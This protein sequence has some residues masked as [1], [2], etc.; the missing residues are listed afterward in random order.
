M[1]KPNHDSEGNVE[2][3]D[4]QNDPLQETGSDSPA[5]HAGPTPRA[6]LTAV[7]LNWNGSDDTRQC[8]ASLEAAGV[9][10]IVVDNGSCSEDVAR[11]ADAVAR[12][13]GATLLRNTE[14]L[15]F[16]SGCNVGIRAALERGARLVLLLNNDATLEP[17]AVDALLAFADSNPRAG[18]VSPLI[19]DSTG[20]RI[21]AAGG[22][23]ARREVVCGLGLTGKPA[24]AAPAEPFQS[25]ALTGC[26]LLIRREVFD[27]VG[28]FDGDYFAYVEDV[29]LSRR[30]ASAGWGLWVVPK[31]RVR[32]RVS[33]SSGGGYTP[34]RSYLLGRGTALFVRKRASLDQRI[35]FTLLAPL[36]LLAALVRETSRGNSRAVLAKARGY[37]DGLLGRTV[38]ER[39]FKQNPER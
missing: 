6:L 33:G 38:D 7:V 23:R 11:V 16:A 19:L 20:E 34:L 17:G 35:G 29:D 26:A 22:V 31:A 9:E 27:E 12:M 10:A 30:A 14:N 28:Y 32:H 13:T 37:V 15:G 18:L 24:E 8:L 21:W 36:G 5:F 25:Y 4:D 2:L 39:Y 1:R 3:R